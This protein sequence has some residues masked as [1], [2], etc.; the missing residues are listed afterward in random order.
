MLTVLAIGPLYFAIAPLQVPTHFAYADLEILTAETSVPLNETQNA[1]EV[2][3]RSADSNFAPLTV[4]LRINDESENSHLSVRELKAYDGQSNPYFISADA[5]P[6][7]VNSS[8][9]ILDSEILPSGLPYGGGLGILADTW[10]SDNAQL[11]VT[12]VF[13]AEL[14]SSISIEIASPSVLPF[15]VIQHHYDMDI[16]GNSSSQEITIDDSFV[17]P[18]IHCETCTKVESRPD[19]ESA[20]E[21]AYVTN[22]TDLSLASKLTWWA[23]GDGEVTF[24]VAGSSGTNDSISYAKEVA[25]MLDDEWRQVEVDLNGTDLQNVTHPFGFSLTEPGDRTMYLKGMIFN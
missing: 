19:G 12:V 7:Q 24:R 13:V 11:D 5:Q 21:A 14:N 17:D 25:A 18:E 22:A 20:I 1:I 4:M 10:N 23:M 8:A 2:K 3:I 9:A 15:D 16:T 6:Q